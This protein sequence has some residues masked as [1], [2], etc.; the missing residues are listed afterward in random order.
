LEADRQA[1]ASLLRASP[2]GMPAPL[3]DE[4]LKWLD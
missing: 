2:F 1:F 3:R 4:P